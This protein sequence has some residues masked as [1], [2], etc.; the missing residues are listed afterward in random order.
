MLDSDAATVKQHQAAYSFI[1]CQQTSSID[2]TPG[3]TRPLSPR[4]PMNRI[5]TLFQRM[6]LNLCAASPTDNG[7]PVNWGF[8]WKLR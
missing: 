8:Q 2:A 7:N 5:L 4:A 6:E 3:Y 1:L